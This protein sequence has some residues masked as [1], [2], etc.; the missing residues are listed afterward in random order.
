[1]K[2]TPGKSAW[3]YGTPQHATEVVEACIREA[4]GMWPRLE[5]QTTFELV[6]GSRVVISNLA[7]SIVHDL[8]TSGAMLP[9]I[10]DVPP[11]AREG[12]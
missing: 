1:M 7:A 9:A 4:L 5:G 8:V 11:A 3:D 12:R 6:T 10:P 2:L